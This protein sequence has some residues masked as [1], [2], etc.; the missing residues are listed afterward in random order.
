MEAV[1]GRSLD[2]PEHE[3][4]AALLGDDAARRVGTIPLEMLELRADAATP[5]AAVAKSAG[6]QANVIQRV[7][8]R[9]IA[10]RLLVSMPAVPVG[11]S[12]FPV[13][14]TGTAAA[15]K[16]AGG[17]QE[18]E[19]G[20]FTG[21]TLDPV[22]LTARYLFRIED[23]YKLR[24]FENVLRRDLVAVMSDKMDD[25]IINGTGA[26]PQV[27]GFINELVAANAPAAVTTWA[28][29]VA[30]FTGLVNGLDAYV[31]R[32]LRSI[33]GAQTFSYAETLYRANNSDLSA[34]AYMAEKTGGVSVSS[35]IASGNVQTNITALTSYPGRNAV[36]P[37]WKAMEIIRDNITQAAS[38][39]IAITAIILWNFKIVRE[40]GFK[41]WKTRNSV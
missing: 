5:V 15:M 11:S 32:D 13:M 3:V 20:S 36:A 12:N 41:A 21:F 25:Q 23:V 35:R 17:L 1:E 28:Q 18:A 26:A 37:V 29:F 24:N 16:A 6:H 38:G 27:S 9:S 30:S 4:R 22:R 2:G 19:A 40:T 10:S 34:F 39:Q 8:S 7:F 14:L 31:L 33:V